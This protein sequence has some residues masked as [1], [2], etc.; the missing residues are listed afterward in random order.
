MTFRVT[1]FIDSMFI[2]LLS[3]LCRF[4]TLS[5]LH[6][7]ISLSLSFHLW[8]SF[9]CFNLVHI[10]NRYCAAWYNYYVNMLSCKSCNFL[11][12]IWLI[13][14]QVTRQSQKFCP[15]AIMFLQTLLMAAAN[16]KMVQ[17]QDFQAWFPR[18]LLC[19]LFCSFNI[20]MHLMFFFINQAVNCLAFTWDY[21]CW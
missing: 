8:W 14:L 5:I 20:R 11:L 16:M 12:F 15:E 6:S 7:L 10:G 13:L 2:Q 4:A 17:C 21:T 19:V 1:D 18:S 3:S 9:E